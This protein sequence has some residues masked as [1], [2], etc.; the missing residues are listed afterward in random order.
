MRKRSAFF[1]LLPHPFRLS[2]IDEEVFDKKLSRKGK[3]RKQMTEAAQTYM[4]D[5]VT[6]QAK[7]LIYVAQI[8]QEI[9]S[10]V[11]SL[12]TTQSVNLTRLKSLCRLGAHAA[13]SK[14][15]FPRPGQKLSDTEIFTW[16]TVL[17][18][19]ALLVEAHLSDFIAQGN[20]VNVPDYSSLSPTLPQGD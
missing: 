13:V 1:P 6:Y 14:E 9:N 7:Y 10:C 12:D 16:R 8:G 4:R 15:R 18:D 19:L 3:S 17:L 20:C 5:T 2:V 11:E